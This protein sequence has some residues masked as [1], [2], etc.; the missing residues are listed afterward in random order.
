MLSPGAPARSSWLTAMSPGS[1][2]GF[3]Q[4]MNRE[5]ATTRWPNRIS[6]FE[7]APP[8][9]FLLPAII[10]LL[11]ERPG[12]GYSLVKE[13]QEFRFGQ[14]DR[15]SVYRALAQ[16]ERDG[17]VTSRSEAPKAGQARRVYR[18]TEQGE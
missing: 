18:L 10:L 17:L 13:L 14:V 12:Y 2:E 9:H 7:L 3:E 8:R 5:T 16:L 1:Y 4:A 6:R 11:S 15:P